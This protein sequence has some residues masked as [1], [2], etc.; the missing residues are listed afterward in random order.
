MSERF[1]FD[2]A[3]VNAGYSIRG[4]ARAAGVAQ[5]TV[6]RLA[7]G[8]PVRPEQAKKVAD[9]LGVQVIDLIPLD[10]AEAA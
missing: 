1:D 6:Q 10:P 5:G 2:R 4:L 3:R 9:V 8:R 7:A